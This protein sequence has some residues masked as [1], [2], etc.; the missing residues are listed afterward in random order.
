MDLSQIASVV[1]PGLNALNAARAALEVR[2]YVATATAIADATAK[3]L[4]AQERL[5][6]QI[7]EIDNLRTELRQVKEE[8]AELKRLRLQREKY[9]PFALA[10][11]AVVF[12][13]KPP[14]K[15][16]EIGVDPSE[17]PHYV[18]QN[19]LDNRG[20]LAILIPRHGISLDCPACSTSVPVQRV[21]DFSQPIGGGSQF[22]RDW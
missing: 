8:L 22:T 20:V 1:I 12:R 14:A 19:C 6:T 13:L 21:G 11:E 17:P 9:A 3:L 5:A 18:C 2:D 7:T 16:G 4:D 10:S 15:L